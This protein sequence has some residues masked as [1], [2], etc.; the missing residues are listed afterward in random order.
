M[1]L[2]IVHLTQSLRGLLTTT[3]PYD[4]N[5]ELPLSATEHREE[6]TTTLCAVHHCATRRE[7]V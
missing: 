4:H 3:F 7:A 1:A 2:S 6:L 5:A